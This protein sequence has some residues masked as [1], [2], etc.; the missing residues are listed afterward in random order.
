[1]KIPFLSQLPLFQGISP[2]ELDTL[3]PKLKIQTREFQKGDVIY[4]AGDKTS[5]MGILVN[6]KIQMESTDLW[7]THYVLEVL[8]P[9]SIFAHY[10]MFLSEESIMVDMVAR[11][12]SIVVFLDADSILKVSSTNPLLL[13]N[14]F[15]ICAQSN[16]NLCRKIYHTSYK[17]IRGRLR[18]YLSYESLR[19]QNTTIN[20]PFDRQ[21][22]ADYLN[23]DRSALSNELSKMQKEGLLEVQ[24]NHFTFRLNT[25]KKEEEQ[26]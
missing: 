21:S 16:L 6:G 25:D 23:V 11:E 5:K 22:L 8:K 20:I 19:Q 4:R 2:Q 3:L 14:L 17:T 1:M 7:G 9:K 18:A 10:Y 24:K 13:K 12:Q 26:E 15:K